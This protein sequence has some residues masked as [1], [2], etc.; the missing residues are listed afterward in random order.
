MMKRRFALFG[1]LFLTL[2][3]MAGLG[4]Q[5][6]AWA[7]GVPGETIP[8]D[9][10]P[11]FLPL[12]SLAQPTPTSTIPPRVFGSVPV[13]GGSIGRPAQESPDVN[14]ALRGFTPTSA[15]LGLVNYGGHTDADAP[16]VAEMFVPPRLPAFVGAH[17]V[18]DWDW[19]CNPPA[20]C[21]S[22]PITWPYSVSLIDLATTPGETLAIPS[23]VP[24]IYGGGYKAM[25]LYAEARR[26]TL[27]YTR[28]D[29]PAQGYLIHLEELAVAPEL[30]AL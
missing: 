28:E 3:V 10:T 9:A 4:M 11:M 18:Y 7:Q 17:Q 12:I 25:V 8:P 29:T 20:G 30:V 5:A 2:V 13:A 6:P 24:Q 16:Q 22:N 14:L 21:R 15:Y 19:G 1:V 27:A 23:R 26:V